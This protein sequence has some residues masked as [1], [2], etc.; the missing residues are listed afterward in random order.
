M[1]AIWA[2][3]IGVVGC[4][5]LIS[6]G[7]WQVQRLQ[8][9]ESVVAEIDAR[10]GGDPAALP[11]VPEPERDRYLPVRLTGTVGQD[12]L[13]VLT[14]IKNVGPGYRVI[15]P[16]ETEG[17]MILLD[18]GYIA[19]ADKDAARGGQAITVEGN[20]HWPDETDGFTPAPDLGRNIWFARDVA[21]MAEALGTE[22][23]MVIARAT[24][25]DP[26]A[27]RPL[28]VTT[29]G[30]PNDH[31]EYAITWFSLATVWAGM[32]A[33]LLWRIRRRTV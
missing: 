17:R 2:I 22:P 21:A 31:L 20:V 32:T 24:S 23:V 13:H 9:K 3:L 4:A 29:E 6:L 16:F 12:E 19:E 25:E 15:A 27:T 28:P 26:P 10:I 8:W 11:A 33:F 5:I 18:R 30:I 7:V 14:S 1:R